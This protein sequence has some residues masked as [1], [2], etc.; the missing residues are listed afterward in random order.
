MIKLEHVSMKFNLGI[1]KEFSIKQAFVNFFSFNKPKKKKEWVPD[2]SLT[3]DMPELHQSTGVVYDAKDVKLE[4]DTTLRN[5]SDDDAVSASNDSMDMRDRQFANV[6]DAMK[7]NN[8]AYFQ[9]PD[10]F[11]SIV[12]PSI[13]SKRS[14]S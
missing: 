8:I 1:E 14:A 9:I 12:A 11:F 4:E 2:E 13:Q 7:R 5:L 10:D 3:A 6:K